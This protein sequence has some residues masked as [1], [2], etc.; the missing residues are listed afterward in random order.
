MSKSLEGLPDVFYAINVF[1]GCFLVLLFVLIIVNVH[2]DEWFN[3]SESVTKLIQAE[4]SEILRMLHD[5][6]AIYVQAVYELDKDGNRVYDWETMEYSFYR[7]MEILV[8][9]NEQKNR[10]EN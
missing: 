4:E 8:S 6:E 7:D 5:D 9:L 2:G 3:M 1:V 10:H